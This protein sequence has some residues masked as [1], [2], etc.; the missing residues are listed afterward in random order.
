MPEGS[1]AKV[2][3]GKSMYKNQEKSVRRIQ[4]FTTAFHKE[5]VPVPSGWYALEIRAGALTDVRTV[6][7]GIPATGVPEQYDNTATLL[8]STEKIRISLTTSNDWQLIACSRSDPVLCLVLVG[9]RSG[10]HAEGDAKD[11]IEL[12]IPDAWTEEIKSWDNFVARIYELPPLTEPLSCAAALLVSVPPAVLFLISVWLTDDGLTIPQALVGSWIIIALGG[13]LYHVVHAGVQVFWHKFLFPYVRVTTLITYY[14]DR[15][16]LSECKKSWFN[17]SRQYLEK[18]QE[19]QSDSSSTPRR[20]TEFLNEIFRIQR[21]VDRSYRMIS[22]FHK[23]KI[24][25]SYDGL[26]WDYAINL[27]ETIEDRC[28]F[29]REVRCTARPEHRINS[30]ETS[31]IAAS[32]EKKMQAASTYIFLISD[33]SVGHNSPY[34]QQEIALAVH[35]VRRRATEIN[36]YSLRSSIIPVV[37][38]NCFRLPGLLEKLPGFFIS[39]VSMPAQQ[40]GTEALCIAINA[41][42]DR[43]TRKI[44]DS[45]EQRDEF[46][47]QTQLNSTKG[48]IRDIVLHCRATVT[49]VCYSFKIGK[50]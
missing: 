22:S 20:E 40:P 41:R 9:T 31:E 7:R 42:S 49:K 29:V 27:A 28:Q 2:N 10:L 35:L 8:L 45:G 19:L 39:R 11:L 48:L 37:L 3:R 43:L 13:L 21:E 30:H 33:R 32:L 24:F 38:G 44:G 34:V 46:L 17:R 5:Y 50:S 23:Q 26:D 18:K 6:P 12:H 14:R 16:R 1:T 15:R 36:N 25:L 4:E 47:K